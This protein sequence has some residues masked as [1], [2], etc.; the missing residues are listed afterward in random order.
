V[1]LLASDTYTSPWMQPASRSNELLGPWMHPASR[2]DG[3]LG[4]VLFDSKSSMKKNFTW[5]ITVTISNST[6]DCFQYVKIVVSSTNAK[7]LHCSVFAVRAWGLRFI[8]TKLKLPITNPLSNYTLVDVDV[9]LQ[10]SNHKINWKF[11]IIS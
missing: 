5:G 10:I 4:L 11:F 6:S 2:S 8:S 3:L 1:L 7:R 9:N